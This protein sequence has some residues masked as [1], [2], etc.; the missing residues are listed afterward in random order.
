MRS[1]CRNTGYLCKS[2]IL[3]NF[4]TYNTRVYNFCG[5]LR[6]K[7]IV[8]E[9]A[10]HEHSLHHFEVWFRVDHWVT[11]WSLRSFWFLGL[12]SCVVAGL[13]ISRGAPQ[14]RFESRQVSV[15]KRACSVKAW[16]ENSVFGCSACAGSFSVN[17]N[18]LS[19]KH[20]SCKHN[21]FCLRRQIHLFL[22]I[23]KRL[24]IKPFLMQFLNSCFLSVVGYF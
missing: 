3:K 17:S 10:A 4:K 20:K 13:S 6:L 2:C 7:G 18:V 9:V 22:E 1:R 15:V 14:D 11:C 16:A 23:L 8:V 19:F 21:G 12:S 24:N 5:R